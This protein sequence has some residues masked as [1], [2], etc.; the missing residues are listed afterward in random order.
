MMNDPLK[1]HPWE[2]VI[3]CAAA[4]MNNEMKEKQRAE[5]RAHLAECPSCSQVAA[6]LHNLRCSMKELAEESANVGCGK[7]SISDVLDYLQKKDADS[8]RADEVARHLATCTHCAEFIHEYSSLVNAKAECTAYPFAASALLETISPLQSLADKVRSLTPLFPPLFER[9]I[10]LLQAKTMPVPAFQVTLGTGTLRAFRPLCSGVR[11][12]FDFVWAAHRRA[13]SYLFH[14]S[15]GRTGETYEASFKP[16]TRNTPQK[17]RSDDIEIELETDIQNRWS[18][19][20]LDVEGKKIAETGEIP[21]KI[22]LAE[23]AQLSLRREFHIWKEIPEEIGAFVALGSVGLYDEAVELLMSK[24]AA[25]NVLYA[26]CMVSLYDYR[27]AEY[28]EGVAALHLN[29]LRESWV[30][31]LLE[32]RNGEA[33]ASGTTNDNNG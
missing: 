23:P 16:K 21:F 24:D 31:T 32:L 33:V 2:A 22:S 30:G 17:L 1:N 3:T 9:V 8:P 26:A 18:V 13:D 28:T 12:P 20:A 5:W 7:L 25:A 11:Q 4:D 10:E 6:W 19:D 27:L 15:N 14:V 29:A